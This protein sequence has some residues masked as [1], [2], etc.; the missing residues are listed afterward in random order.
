MKDKKCYT[1]GFG[2]HPLGYGDLF[3]N[4]EQGSDR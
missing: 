4:S 2:Y 3:K 1:Q